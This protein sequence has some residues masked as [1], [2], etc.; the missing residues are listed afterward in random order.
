MATARVALGSIFRTVSDSANAVSSLVNTT[1]KSIGM[2]DK[3]VTKASEEQRKNH[4]RDG[5]LFD[6]NLRISF[7][8][9]K[10]NLLLKAE[11]YCNKSELHKEHFNAAYAEMNALLNPESASTSQ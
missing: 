7:A 11:E 6:E 8:E 9:E 1:T 4:L 10:A 2:L 3:F 5:A